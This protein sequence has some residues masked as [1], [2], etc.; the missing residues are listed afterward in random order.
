MSLPIQQDPPPTAETARPFWVGH[1][2]TEVQFALDLVVL[3]AAF[4]LSYLL[5]FDFAIPPEYVQNALAQLPVVVLIQFSTLLLLGIYSF[6]WRYVGL[7]EVR[8]FLRAAVYSAIPLLALRLG[9]PEEFAAWQVPRSIILLDTLLAFGGLLGIRVLRRSLYER[10]ERQFR[11]V[12]SVEASAAPKRALLAGAGHAGVIAARELRGHHDVE[13]V[14]FVDDDSR[15]LGTVI[16]G[17]KVLGTS[18]DL[19][20]LITDLSIERVLITMTSSGSDV[21]RSILDAGKRAGVEVRIVP[22]LHEIVGGRVAVSRFRHVQIEDLLGREPVRL[23][24]DTVREFISGK[25]VLLSGAGGSIGGELARQIAR[26]NPLRLVIAERSEGALFEIEREL[27]ALWPQMRVSSFLGDVGDTR[28]MAEA[29]RRWRPHLV[30]HAA[31]HKHVTM[32]EQSPSEAIYNNILAT[33]SLGRLAG[34]NGAETFVLVST[35]KAVKPTSVMGA[36][37]RVAELVVQELDTQF[38]DSRFVAVRFGNVLGSAGSVVPIFREQIARGGPVTVTHPDAT[39]Y[40][41]TPSEAAQ[42]V[43]EAGA[44]GEGGDILILDMGEPVRILDLAKDMIALSGYKPFD[45]IPIVFSG[46]RPGEKLVEELQ[47]AGEDVARTAHPKVYSGKLAAYPEGEIAKALATLRDLAEREDDGA[48]RSFLCELLPEANLER[49]RKPD[50]ETAA[51]VS[52][53]TVH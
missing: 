15:K 19:P 41:M 43:L 21:I 30:F 12:E 48:I 51:G 1:L 20:R 39:R 28:R 37:K 26:F 32:M 44:I 33:E 45:E 50:P 16:S 49:R 18:R 22:S 14:G 25:S 27:A 31:A 6:V 36:S 24:K 42:L 53:P 3:V 7:T 17:L 38:T 5:R 47:L 29:F 40:F 46:L 23:D 52:Q 10:F 2:R 11:R 13:P 9:L 4:A 34:E 35:D 8:A